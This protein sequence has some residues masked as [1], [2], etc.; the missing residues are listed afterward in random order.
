MKIADIVHLCLIL[1]VFEECKSYLCSWQRYC[2]DR[3]TFSLKEVNDNRVENKADNRNSIPNRRNIDVIKVNKMKIDESL[4]F[5]KKV[6]PIIEDYEEVLGE[7][8]RPFQ[9]GFVSILG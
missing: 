4:E 5:K 8:D 3:R 6:T 2:Y 7:L 9:S 1:V